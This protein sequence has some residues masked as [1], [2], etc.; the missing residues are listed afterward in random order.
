MFRKSLLIVFVFLGGVPQNSNSDLIEKK[1]RF[2]SYDQA[3]DS[4]QNYLYFEVES[5]KIGLFS[6][7][8]RGFV[9]KFEIKGNFDWNYFC[10]SR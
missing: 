9:K 7:K 10:R 1:Y 8:I 2:E 6:S 3:K 5:T 4:V